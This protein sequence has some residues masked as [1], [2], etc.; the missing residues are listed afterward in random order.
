MYTNKLSIAP[1]FIN[2]IGHKICCFN[3]LFVRSQSTN[4]VNHSFLYL[5]AIDLQTFLDYIYNT[6]II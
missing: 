2:F 1:S 6:H 4:I 3:S 5:E